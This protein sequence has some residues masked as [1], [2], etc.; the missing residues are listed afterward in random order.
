MIT[1]SPGLIEGSMLPLKIT[2]GESGKR[3]AMKAIAN[4][5]ITRLVIHRLGFKE[6]INLDGISFLLLSIEYCNIK[7]VDK[8]YK[9]FKTIITNHS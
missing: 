3:P 8:Q 7:Y 1:K 5:I 2:T 4:K 9:M 6:I